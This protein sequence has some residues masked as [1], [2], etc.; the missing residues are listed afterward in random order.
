MDKSIENI[1]KN[2]FERDSSFLA[3]RLAKLYQ[4]KSALLT[5]KL[6]RTYRIDNGLL[7]LLAVA[8][9]VLGYF[10]HY[11]VTGAYGALWLMA[12]FF[13]NRQQ[14]AKLET[15]QVTDDLYNYLCNYR[16]IIRGMMKFYTR[17]LGIGLPLIG[18]PPILIYLR[19]QHP[20]V[21]YQLTSDNL[22]LS[23]SLLILLIAVLSGVGIGAYHLSTRAVYGKL[24][25]RLT[26]M[27]EDIET[28]KPGA[29]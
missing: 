9:L 7:P 17:V 20:E 25:D 2:G 13:L 24:L 1:W 14:L 11:P 27:I 3:P 21:Y 26:T 29:F 23:I 12:L 18:I 28:L 19:E 8:L 6:K 5:A 10:M 16:Q 22:F 15:V 4:Q